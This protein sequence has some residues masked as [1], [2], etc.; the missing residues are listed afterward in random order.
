[1]KAVFIHPVTKAEIALPEKTKIDGSEEELTFL[2]QKSSGWAPG[3][4][5]Q[6]EEGREFIVKL[7]EANRYLEKSSHVNREAAIRIQKA[8]RNQ[9]LR[10][11]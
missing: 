10:G 7:E 11:I 5:Y 3:G 4:W 6:D 9:Q 1:M 2:K 8:F